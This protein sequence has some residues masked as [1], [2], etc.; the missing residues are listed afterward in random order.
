MNTFVNSIFG[1][2]VASALSA[3]TAQ[4]AVIGTFIDQGSGLFT[5]E[6]TNTDGAAYNAFE[7]SFSGNFL[8]GF[9]PGASTT[10]A[11]LTGI[12][13]VGSPADT[14]FYDPEADDLVAGAAAETL[15]TLSKAYA[16]GG[17]DTVALNETQILAVFSTSDNTTP[18]LVSGFA[19]AGAGPVEIVIPEPTSLALLGLGGL[20]V[21]RR[22]R[23]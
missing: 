12:P 3:G 14:Y 9:A 5:F 17:G 21:A 23:G 1:L 15:T 16:L 11:T 7:L 22:R 6:V 19:S 13:F 4:A 2:A 18:T 8:Q 20:M 10:A